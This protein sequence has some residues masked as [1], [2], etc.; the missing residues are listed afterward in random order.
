MDIFRIYKDLACL[1]LLCTL[2]G[3]QIACSEGVGD[4][5]TPEYVPPEGFHNTEIY[6][7]TSSVQCQTRVCGVFRYSGDPNVEFETDPTSLERKVFCTCRCRAPNKNFTT[8]E[9][10]DGFVCS[11]DVLKNAGDALRGGYCIRPGNMDVTNK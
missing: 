7:E 8:C 2:G 9:C 11:E 1:L 3:L 6:I 10:P 5:C 4:P